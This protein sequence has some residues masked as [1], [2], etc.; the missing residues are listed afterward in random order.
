MTQWQN[1]KSTWENNKN[2]SQHTSIASKSSAITIAQYANWRTQ[3][4]TKITS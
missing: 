1:I 4:W 3:Q 2:V